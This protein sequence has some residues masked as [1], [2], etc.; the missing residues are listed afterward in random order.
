MSRS[1]SILSANR[2]ALHLHPESHPVNQISNTY[3]RFYA[4]IG[5]KLSKISLTVSLVRLHAEIK[6]RGLDAWIVAC[7]H[8][9]IWL[10]TSMEEEREVRRIMEGVTTTAMSLLAPPLVDFEE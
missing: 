4:K 10:E 1:N 6:R 7:I 5:R 2:L 8:D 3:R 9:A